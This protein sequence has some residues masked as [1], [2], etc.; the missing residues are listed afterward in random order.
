MLGIGSTQ[1][2]NGFVLDNTIILKVCNSALKAIEN[3][4]PEEARF[5]EVYCQII[6]DCKVVLKEKKIKI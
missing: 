4:L 3:E 6:D 1:F 5:F 2:S